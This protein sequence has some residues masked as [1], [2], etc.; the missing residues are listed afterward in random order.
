MARPDEGGHARHPRPQ[1]MPERAACERA[2][3][4]R[5]ALRTGDDG[6]ARP[7]KPAPG[8]RPYGTNATTR[9]GAALAPTIRSG[10][11]ATWKP[12]A[13]S[14]PRLTRRSICE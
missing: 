10:K 6:R 9:A 11:H 7:T 5:E 8:P 3:E 4:R 2:N 14:S 1:S 13:G 12:V